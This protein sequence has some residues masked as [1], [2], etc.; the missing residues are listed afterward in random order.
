MLQSPITF[1][2]LQNQMKHSMA[3]NI[4]KKIETE[5]RTFFCLRMPHSKI[6]KI[7]NIRLRLRSFSFSTQ[8]SST[9]ILC[10]MQA[11]SGGGGG[12]L[13]KWEKCSYHFIKWFR[14]RHQRP[15]QAHRCR[16]LL[17]FLSFIRF[18]I[19]IFIYLRKNHS[20][21]TMTSMQ[22][23]LHDTRGLNKNS[24]FF[25]LEPLAIMQCRRQKRHDS[26]VKCE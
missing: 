11:H 24:F 5:N 1:I 14:L 17:F 26:F 6:K 3:T 7:T 18:S 4:E 16:C 8:V 23:I 15:T 20:S 13:E 22:R 10:A 19:Y 2:L 12:D 9:S 21:D 25:S